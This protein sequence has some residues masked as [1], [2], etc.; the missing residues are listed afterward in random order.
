MTENPYLHSATPP[1]SAGTTEVLNRAECWRLLGITRIAR[2]AVVD[3]DGPDIFPINYLV[4]GDSLFFRSAPGKKIVDL[5]KRP[6]V[7]VE[8]DGTEGGK[9]F[10]VVLR[11]EAH[12]L[13]D[14]ADIRGSAIDSLPTLTGSEKWNYFEVVPRTVTGIRFRASR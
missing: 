2:L 13:S 14:D 10:S 4:T 9:R 8:I 1:P 5:T 7:A 6:G 12:R 3:E 11:G